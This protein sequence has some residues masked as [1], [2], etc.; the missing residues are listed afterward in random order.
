MKKVFLLIII[1][2]L[3]LIFSTQKF[4]INKKIKDQYYQINQKPPI[5]HQ[6]SKN[7]ILSPQTN[8]K[9]VIEK[10]NFSIFVPYWQL[11]KNPNEIKESKIFIK[12]KNKIETHYI[13]FGITA[14]ENGIDKNENGFFNLEKINSS[15]EEHLFSSLVLRLLNDE[16]NFKI[17]ENNNLQKKIIEDTIKITKEKNFSELILDLEIN[18]LPFENV[19]KKINFFVDNFAQKAKIENLIFSMTIYADTFYRKRPY[20]IKFI[21]SK[22]EKIY[23][24]AYDFHKTL[25]NPGPNFPLFG[26]KEYGYDLSSCVKDFLTIVPKEKLI[27]VFGLYG[28]DWTVDKENRPIKAA[29]AITLNQIKKR[30]LSDPK[31]QIKRDALSFEN[32]IEYFDNDFYQHIVWFEDEVSVEKKQEFLLENGVYQFGYWAFGYY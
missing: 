24:M 7:I 1:L 23:V 32:K 2:I 13:Y 28:Y 3:F 6:I 8:Q 11:P 26:K 12:N 15:K 25:G 18:A 19:I 9:K 20:D 22:T 14:D 29:S 21:S 10:I 17:L 16:I 4:I 30:F 27:F 31:I 5:T